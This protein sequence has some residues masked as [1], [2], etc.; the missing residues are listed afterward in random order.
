M[1]LNFFAGFKITAQNKGSDVYKIPPYKSYTMFPTY[2]PYTPLLLI[3]T[4]LH[5]IEKVSG[6]SIIIHTL[7]EKGRS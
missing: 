4:P 1:L 2:S 3:E 5:G 7:T 6:F